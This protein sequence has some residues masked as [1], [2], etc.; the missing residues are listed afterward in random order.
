MNALQ[1]INALICAACC[2]RLIL[3]ARS[4]ATHRP[5][6]SALAY[7]MI[8]AFGAMAV[9]TVFGMAPAISWPQL[10]LNLV[11]AAAVFSVGGNVV[12]LFRPYGSNTQPLILRLL[13]REKW[14]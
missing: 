1:L 2:L 12:E 3:F 7:L 5:W 8:V 4:G 6:A 9:L 11:L 13:R 14:I 10:V